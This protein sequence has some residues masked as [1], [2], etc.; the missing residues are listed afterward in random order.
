M[1]EQVITFDQIKDMSYQKASD[2]LG[3]AVANGRLPREEGWKLLNENLEYNTGS[4]TVARLRND[5]AEKDKRIKK[6]EATI[7]QQQEHIDATNRVL[8]ATDER[9]DKLDLENIRLR[10]ACNRASD[11][12]AEARLQIEYLEKKFAAGTGSGEAVK[13]KIQDA[14]K[15]IEDSLTASAETTTE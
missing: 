9:N 2:F 4:N 10:G 8:A 1:P 11:V 12:L 7:R 13:A 6:L 3:E 5:V 15:L 14:T